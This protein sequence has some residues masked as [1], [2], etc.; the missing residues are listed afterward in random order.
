MVFKNMKPY[1][2]MKRA[3][4]EDDDFYE[5]DYDILD[6]FEFD[7]DDRPR[8]ARDMDKGGS[9]IKSMIKLAMGIAILFGVYAMLP[10]LFK[11]LILLA[12]EF[13]NWVDK[14]F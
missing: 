5:G 9:I 1:K 4:D 13:F 2:D 3:E 11:F 12:K 8:A 14:L 6:P 7:T 10:G